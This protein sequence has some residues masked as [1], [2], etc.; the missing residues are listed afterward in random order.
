[1]SA[2][3]A[4]RCWIPAHND[5]EHLWVSWRSVQERLYFSYRHQLNHTFTVKPCG[6]LKVKNALITSVYCVTAY[7][8]CSGVISSARLHWLCSPPNLLYSVHE[9][10][11][12]WLQRIWPWSLLHRH[13]TMPN[14]KENYLL[15]Q[16]AL[17]S[18]TLLSS[19]YP[20]IFMAFR[21]YLF[22]HG[23]LYHLLSVL[24]FFAVSY[25]LSPYLLLRLFI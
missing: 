9:L 22:I 16:H 14:P 15:L 4:V 20:Y 8:I 24:L 17:H 25:N 19:L 5:V 12:F 11:C 18:F 3:G 13:N 6:I 10:L 7:T 21:S 23:I 2:W 1:M